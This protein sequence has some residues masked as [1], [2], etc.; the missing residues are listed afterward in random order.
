MPLE[1]Y[2]EQSELEDI[3]LRYTNVQRCIPYTLKRLQQSPLFLTTIEYLKSEEWKE[4]HILQAIFNGVM[5]WYA[6]QSGANQD[7][8]RIRKEGETLLRRLLEKGESP[9]D[10]SIPPNYFT[11]EAMHTLLNI[12]IMTYLSTK[13]A[14]FGQRSYNPERMRTIV[15]DRY[16]YFELDVPHSPVFPTRTNEQS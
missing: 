8:Q 16:H 2:N 13:G 9:Q 1:P 11:L 10:T 3:E 4:W 15:K 14:V 5:S 7:V 6:E 12:G